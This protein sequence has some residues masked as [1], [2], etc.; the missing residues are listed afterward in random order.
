MYPYAQSGI[1]VICACTTTAALYIVSTT[2]PA[3]RIL[4]VGSL[5]YDLAGYRLPAAGR[6]ESGPGS[7]K[8]NE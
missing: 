5:T 7:L 4:M 8:R 3:S 1:V 6:R 2:S